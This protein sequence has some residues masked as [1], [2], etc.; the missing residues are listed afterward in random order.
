[1]HKVLTI[2]GSDSGAGAGIAADLKTFQARGVYGISAITAVTAQN[3]RGVQAIHVVPAS[4]VGL[5]IDSVMSDIGADA[6]KT[7]MLGNA[8]IVK[9]VVDKIKQYKVDCVVVDP[10]MISTSGT[11]LL[12][13]HALKTL[14]TKLIP[15]AYIVT[16]N[17][18]EAQVLTGM[19]IASL[20]DMKK[21]AVLLHK[22]GSKNVVI[23]GGH[24]PTATIQQFNNS[25]I[26]VLFDGKTF[27]EF[28]APWIK[29]RN[30]HGTGCTF[31]SAITA[32]VAKGK[33][34][35][36]AVQI[37]KRYVTEALEK[38]AKFRIGHGNGPLTGNS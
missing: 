36:Q 30:T 6:W 32:E 2:A 13:Q 10:V 7:G 33:S 37:A 35:A 15:C 23:K 5:Q 16:P 22:M 17:I 34:V 29:T 21:A 38:S 24:L 9:V 18:P 1:M 4:F 25:T 31:A 19:Q 28:K 27:Q 3:T 14:A 26:D 11:R 20:Q 8:K 12:Q